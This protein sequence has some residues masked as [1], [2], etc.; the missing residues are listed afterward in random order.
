MT[1]GP[2]DTKIRQYIEGLVPQRPKE[3]QLMES[4]AEQ[5]DFPIIGPVC[6]YIC[7]QIA[8]MIGARQVCELGS[9][10]GYST[11]WFAQAVKENGGGTVH[12]IVWDEEL[13]KSAR[14]HLNAMGY[15]GIVEYHVAEAV[16]TLR[17]MTGPFDVIFCDIDKDAYPNA[18]KVMKEKLRSG[19]VAIFDNMLLHGRVLDESDRSPETMGIRQVTQQLMEDPDW[20]ISLIPIRDGLMVAY[21][22]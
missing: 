9:G 22:K 19:S 16:Q 18:L 1:V 10:Y 6:G 7:Y 20:T 17:E 8:R 14:K 2:T 15:D 5:E 21:R 4:Y 12:H 11:A 13:S 3:M